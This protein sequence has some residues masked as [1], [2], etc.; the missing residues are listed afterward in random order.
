MVSY[1]YG[2]ERANCSKSLDSAFDLLWDGVEVTCPYNLKAAQLL[3]AI[4]N[5]IVLL[6]LL[7][8]TCFLAMAVNEEL[9]KEWLPDQWESIPTA[10][11]VVIKGAP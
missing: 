6:S 3:S 11:P 9:S 10:N 5:F 8:F 2:S 7:P 4:L 1:C